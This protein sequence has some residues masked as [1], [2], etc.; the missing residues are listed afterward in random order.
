MAIE[1]KG[2]Q[3]LTWNV[4]TEGTFAEFNKLLRD[5]IRVGIYRG[6][7]IFVDTL[8]NKVVIKPFSAFM[9]MRS[10]IP[11][12][13]KRDQLGISV[14]TEEEIELDLTGL[15]EG[16]YYIIAEHYY[17]VEEPRYVDFRIVPK[18][19]EILEND[20]YLIFGTLYVTINTQTG[21]F[22]YSVDNTHRRWGLFYED[23]KNHF[24]NGDLYLQKHL[25]Y[26]YRIAN[27]GNCDLSNANVVIVP[28]GAI[29]SNTL[30]LNNV[31][32]DVLY[33]ILIESRQEPVTITCNE[34]NVNIQGMQKAQDWNFYIGYV[35]G[36]EFQLWSIIAE[37]PPF[38]RKVNIPNINMLNYKKIIDINVSIQIPYTSSYELEIDLGLKISHIPKGKNKLGIVYQIFD[39]YNNIVKSKYMRIDERDY[40]ILDYLKDITAEKTEE[41][42]IIGLNIN[43]NINTNDQNLEPNYRLNI[44]SNLG[45]VMKK[46]QKR[47]NI[48]GVDSRGDNFS[49]S[50]TIEVFE[51]VGIGSYDKVNNKFFVK[52]IDPNF[53]YGIISN[54]TKLDLFPL[55]VDNPVYIL[56]KSSITVSESGNDNILYIPLTYLLSNIQ[57][58]SITEAQFFDRPL[59]YNVQNDNPDTFPQL[60]IDL[61]YARKVAECIKNALITYTDSIQLTNDATSTKMYDYGNVIRGLNIIKDNRQKIFQNDF[62]VFKTIHEYLPNLTKNYVLK[63]YLI[64]EVENPDNYQNIF[65]N[66]NYDY[67]I[68]N[69]PYSV[70]SSITLKETL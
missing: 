51:P 24:I 47:I 46:V 32:R 59:N 56:S 4:G 40:F 25:R 29:P 68:D 15:S 33:Y 57:N 70:E 55:N 58:V 43:T 5:I 50:T 22:N 39:T 17:S 23:N 63:F 16:T 38:Y 8:N 18:A 31:K 41:H 53:E 20:Y 36:S 61:K 27:G 9:K 37:R 26:N 67:N 11:N 19:Q 21:K 69:F 64:H 65:Y 52:E 10:E 30:Q 6:G 28:K 54:Y 45:L 3:F 42:L 49:G 14:K 62:E 2:S 48:N 34:F 60:K 7:E 66:F 13:E 44:F 35:V 12:L 1:N